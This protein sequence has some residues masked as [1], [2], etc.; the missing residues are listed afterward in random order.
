[1]TGS[2]LVLVLL[3]AYVLTDAGREAAAR[4]AHPSGVTR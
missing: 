4:L 3:G 2:T 1:M